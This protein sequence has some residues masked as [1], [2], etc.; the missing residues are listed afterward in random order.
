MSQN[1]S[2]V[3]G[4]GTDESADAS[5]DD[6]RDAGDTAATI[7]LPA[8]GDVS[9]SIPPSATPAETAAI[10]AVIGAHLRDQEAAA[11]AAGAEDETWDGERWAFAGRL[12]A[13]GERSARV[14]AGAPTDPWSAAGRTDRF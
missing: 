7:D 2:P 10:A 6:R 11:A 12:D 14:P 5:T 4:D 3:S 9:L 1:E 8:D 13:L